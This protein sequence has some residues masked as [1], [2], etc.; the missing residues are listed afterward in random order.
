MELCFYFD[1]G[2]RDDKYFKAFIDIADEI[3]KLHKVKKFKLFVVIN[4]D[5]LQPTRIDGKPLCWTDVRRIISDYKKMKDT[6]EWILY[7]CNDCD[8]EYVMHMENSWTRCEECAK[9]YH[10]SDSDCEECGKNA[11]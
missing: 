2:L 7:N 6:E 11:K 8:K 10:G 9:H 5:K 3:R 1:K 4:D